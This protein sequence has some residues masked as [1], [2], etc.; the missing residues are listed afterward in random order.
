MRKCLTF[1]NRLSGKP[2]RP[3]EPEIREIL[4]QVGVVWEA[5]EVVDE[6]NGE[7]EVDEEYEY[8]EEEGEEE[9]YEE[10]DE[11]IEIEDMEDIKT[12]DSDS[13]E[14]KENIEDSKMKEDGQNKDLETEEK[15]DQKEKDGES[16]GDIPTSNVAAKRSVSF[17]SC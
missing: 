17:L 2:H 8:I 16:K 9:E 1:L 3:R 13:K 10:V 7:V 12:K 11:E 15:Q 6:E 14:V 4:A 5:Q